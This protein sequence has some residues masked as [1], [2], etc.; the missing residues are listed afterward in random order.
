MGAG[1]SAPEDIQKLA[2][3]N[4]NYTPPLDVNPVG[5]GAGCLA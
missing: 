1:Q 3:E 4:V 2:K 5:R